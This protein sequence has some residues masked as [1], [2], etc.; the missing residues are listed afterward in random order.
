MHLSEVKTK[1]CRSK[2][3]RAQETLTCQQLHPFPLL[4]Q[5]L[6]ITRDQCTIKGK[7]EFSRDVWVVCVSQHPFSHKQRVEYSCGGKPKELHGKLLQG[8]ANMVE[9][10][11]S[12]GGI[13]NA[14]PFGEVHS[15]QK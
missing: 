9:P 4:R 5:R 6:K 14:S 8:N 12:R 10:T 3:L 15:Y 2:M 1:V 7:F 11:G 13:A